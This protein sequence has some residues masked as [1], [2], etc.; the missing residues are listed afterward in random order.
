MWTANSNNEPSI[1]L[2]ARFGLGC[3]FVTFRWDGTFKIFEIL[4]CHD[5]REVEGGK[6]G[7]NNEGD[8]LTLVGEHTLKYIDDIEF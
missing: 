5:S 7:I 1:H 6:E 4:K 8:D 3:L 2:Q